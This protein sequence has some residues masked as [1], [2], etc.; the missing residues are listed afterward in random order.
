MKSVQQDDERDS[1]ALDRALAEIDHQLAKWDAADI[2]GYADS[3]AILS[4]DEIAALRAALLRS[5]GQPA[6]LDV[7]ALARAIVNAVCGS[8][9][10]S[11]FATDVEIVTE[12]IRK[13]LRA[14][15]A[16]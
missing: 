3:G 9:E 8:P 6:P 14:T 5:S 11:G 2:P 7:D 16:R 12:E 1:E 15:S 10:W 4:Y 13:H